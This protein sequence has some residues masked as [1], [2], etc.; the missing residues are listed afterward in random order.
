MIS[1]V[2]CIANAT[3]QTK[4]NKNMNM[5]KAITRVP[6]FSEPF[7]DWYEAE[8]EET[9]LAMWQLDRQTF[10]LPENATVTLE[11]Q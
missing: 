1:Y 11:K 4:P 7:I 2:D 5:Y 10:G 6:S 9:A 3:I 8:N